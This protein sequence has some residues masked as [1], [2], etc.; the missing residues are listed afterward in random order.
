V[1]AVTTTHAPE[2][3]TD[4]DRV[5]AGGLPEVLAWLTAGVSR[6]A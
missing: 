5:A 6:A 3:L 4:A 2:D 1:W